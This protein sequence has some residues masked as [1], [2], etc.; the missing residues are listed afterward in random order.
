MEYFSKIRLTSPASSE[1]H[2]KT[3][4]SSEACVVVVVDTSLVENI[5]AVVAGD[6]VD[7][8]HVWVNDDIHS[9]CCPC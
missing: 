1:S 2:L 5:V 6:K 4:F 8:Q 3:A 9:R 7:D